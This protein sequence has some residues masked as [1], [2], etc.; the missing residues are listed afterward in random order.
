MAESHEIT[1]AGEAI[2]VYEL[3]VAKMQQWRKRARP[4]VDQHESVLR[5]LHAGTDAGDTARIEAANALFDTMIDENLVL[6][7]DLTLDWLPDQSQRDR[8]T[9]AATMDEVLAAFFPLARLAYRSSS[10][11]F[12][13]M[14]RGISE[15]GSNANQTGT[16]SPDPSG[17][18]GTANSTPT[19]ETSFSNHGSSE[20]DT[21]P[22]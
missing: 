18:S 14:W 6:M 4:V 13:A 5:E 19:V 11:F 8:Y 12:L 15:A 20:S 7:L 17:E 21:K 3:P 2:I 10:S 16:N 1:L 9:E 22:E